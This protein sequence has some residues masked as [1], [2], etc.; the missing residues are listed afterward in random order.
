MEFGAQE[1]DDGIPPHAFKRFMGEVDVGHPGGAI[2]GKS[3]GG[4]G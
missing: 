3:S 2:L 4:G 1:V